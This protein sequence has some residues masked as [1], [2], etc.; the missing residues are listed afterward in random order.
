MIDFDNQTDF[1]LDLKELEDIVKFL[2]NNSF[3]LILVDNKTIQEINKEYRNI[4]KPTDVLS[5]P[6][7]MVCDDML[8]GSIIISVDKVKEGSKLYNHSELDELKLLLI[9]GL[10]HL[11]GYD[12]EVDNGEMRTKEE[13]IIRY[14]KLPKSLII[15]TGE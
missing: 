15:R 13:E 10:L 2:T 5:F 1:E 12:H 11:L 7:D 4:D 6:L 9:H 8:M 14:F 3:E